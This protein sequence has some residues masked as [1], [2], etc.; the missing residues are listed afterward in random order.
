MADEDKIVVL[1]DQ[2]VKARE[3]LGLEH[4]EV[5]DKLGIDE[6]NLINWE[7]GKS[8]PALEVLWNLAELY[9]RSTDYFLRQVPARQLTRSSLNWW[10]VIP[11]GPIL[12][13]LPAS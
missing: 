13:L 4:R 2:L 12:R 11:V 8:E 5:A 1:K 9:Q 7:M 10:S 6:K 3:S